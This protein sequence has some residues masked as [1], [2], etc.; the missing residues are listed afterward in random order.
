MVKGDG[1]ELLEDPCSSTSSASR[2]VLA[3]PIDLALF[4]EAD[5]FRGILSSLVLLLRCGSSPSSLM[6]DSQ[7][8]RW[9]SFGSMEGPGRGAF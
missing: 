9:A 4:L 1:R 5:G 2:I 6:A 3:S 7:R 8:W